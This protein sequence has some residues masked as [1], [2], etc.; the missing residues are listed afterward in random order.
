MILLLLIEGGILS[1]MM[2]VTRIEK[3]SLNVEGMR[4]ARLSLSILLSA[5]LGDSFF[6]GMT[7]CSDLPN[8]EDVIALLFI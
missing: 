1:T 7:S 8:L 3:L 2:T 4:N 5:S 6:N